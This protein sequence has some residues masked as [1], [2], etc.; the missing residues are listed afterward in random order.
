MI[1][2]RCNKQ[3]GLFWSKDLVQGRYFK[4]L[5]DGIDDGIQIFFYIKWI[6]VAWSLLVVISIMAILVVRDWG[7]AETTLLRAGLFE[8]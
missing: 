1:F 6:D 8:G 4:V 5:S 7:S 2:G 3:F